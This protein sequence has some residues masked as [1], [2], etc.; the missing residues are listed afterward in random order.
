VRKTILLVLILAVL[1]FVTSLVI[2]FSRLDDWGTELANRGTLSAAVSGVFAVILGIIA[3]IVT[4]RVSSSDY[5]AEEDVKTQTAQLLACLRS[6]ILKGVVLSQKAPTA[7]TL[8]TFSKEK[9]VINNFL[10]STTAFAYWSWEG[11]K[12]ETAPPGKGEDWRLFFLYLVDI[13]DAEDAANFRRMVARAVSLEKL[14]TGL[15]K[16]DVGKISHYVSNLSGA[17]GAFRESREKSVIIKAATDVYGQA[18][19]SDQ[20]RGKLLHLK[21]KGITDPN[22]DLFL[23]ILDPA[24]GSADRARA[25]LAAGADPNITDGQLL[26][27]YQSQL[28]DY[29]PS[30]AGKGAP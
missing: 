20:L 10:S 26:A 23:A 16:H 21:N 28:Q 9:E 11:H 13:L 5:K 1:S 7:T 27:K 3:I 29:T 14:L 24:G 6:I 15:S 19:S 2:L 18:P 4:S 8:L 25:A 22:I 12:S 17:V 30:G